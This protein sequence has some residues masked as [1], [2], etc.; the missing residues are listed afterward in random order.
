M[1]RTVETTDHPAGTGMDHHGKTSNRPGKTMD[2]SDNTVPKFLIHE[3]DDYSD[4]DHSDDSNGD[5]SVTDI[6][7]MATPAN[8]Q[9][10]VHQDYIARQRY[11]NV[12]PPPPGAPKLVDIPMASL[13]AYCHPSYGS[14]MARSEPLNIVADGFGGMPIDL[15]G[16]PGVMDGDES[17]KS[18]IWM[19]LYCCEYP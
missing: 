4:D 8:R 7:D 3:N 2:R 14:R 6:D 16:M 15:V 12:L 11:S 18:S 1:N 13:M 5:G 10:V 17:C 19:I 9:H